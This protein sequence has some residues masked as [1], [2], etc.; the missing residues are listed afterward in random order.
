[1]NTTMPLQQRGLSFGGFVLGAFL[2]VVSSIFVFKLIPAYI[3]NSKIQKIF[4][5]IKRD[6]DMQKTSPRE[7]R[8]SFD[9]RASIDDINVIKAADI[10]IGGDG[11]NLALSA[12]YSVKF[13]LIANISLIMEFSPSSGK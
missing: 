10:E 6:P 13:P 3:Q 2:L 12:N 11:G 9:R 7:I 1:M 8:A 4:T 5:D